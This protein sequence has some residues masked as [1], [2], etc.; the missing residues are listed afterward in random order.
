MLHFFCHQ[1]MARSLAQLRK[2]AE[3]ARSFIDRPKKGRKG[4]KKGRRGKK[5]YKGMTMKQRMAWVRSHKQ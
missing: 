2:A 4:R 5:S 1:N 3:Y